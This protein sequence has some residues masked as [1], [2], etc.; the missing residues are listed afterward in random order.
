MKEIINVLLTGVLLF[1]YAF[2]KTASLSQKGG[3]SIRGNTVIRWNVLYTCNLGNE[4]GEAI[5]RTEFIPCSH[6]STSLLDILICVARPTEH[7]VRSEDSELQSV[8]GIR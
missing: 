3:C 7:G 5:K 2:S 1:C 6:V 4:W 8:S